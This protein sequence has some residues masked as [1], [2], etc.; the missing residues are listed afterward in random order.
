[1]K[2]QLNLEAHERRFGGL[3]ATHKGLITS[4]QQVKSNAQMTVF[5]S[6]LREDDLMISASQVDA[7]EGSRSI[8]PKSKLDATDKSKVKTMID[9]AAV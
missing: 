6:S 8:R 1:M 7:M 5:A 2:H 4:E 3:A 9:A